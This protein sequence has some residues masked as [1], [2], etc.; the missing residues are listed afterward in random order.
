MLASI[1]T[2]KCEHMPLT[3]QKILQV[4]HYTLEGIFFI[5]LI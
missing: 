4:Y 5:L 1:F 3:K 2:H